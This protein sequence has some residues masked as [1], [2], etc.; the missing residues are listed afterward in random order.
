MSKSDEKS[1]SKH[2]LDS[3]NT[4]AVFTKNAIDGTVENPATYSKS[5]VTMSE[6]QCS[7]EFIVELHS[8]LHK[9]MCGAV[10]RIR[11]RFPAIES[12]GS[13]PTIRVH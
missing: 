6:D 12:I 2:G 5:C 8:G 10:S 7:N 13:V 11:R 3:D 4:S 9:S 1:K